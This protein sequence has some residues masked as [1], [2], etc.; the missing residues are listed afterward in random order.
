MVFAVNAVED[1]PRNFTA[2]QSLAIQL[3]GTNATGASTGT[4]SGSTTGSN[5][6]SAGS[7]LSSAFS[8]GALAAAV[9]VLL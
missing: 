2:F 9:A 8:L 4:G 5:G 1:S 3:N 6:A 7:V